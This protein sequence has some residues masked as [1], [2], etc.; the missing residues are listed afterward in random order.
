MHEKARELVALLSEECGNLEDVQAL[1][2]S[3]FKGTIERM[4]EAEMDE[5]LGYEKHSVLGNNSGNNRNGYGKKVLK[6]ELGETEIEVPRDRNGEFSPRVIEKRQTR[7]DDLENRILAMY[8]KG[9]SNRD[10]EDH[11]RDIYGV[12]ASASLISRITDKILPAV[13][14]WQSRPLDAVYP[15]VFLDGIVF[16]VRKDN[17]VINKCVYSVLG[18]NMDGHKEILGI[19]ISENESASFW[20]TVCNELK[21][22]GVQDILIACRD[23][24]SG[25]STAI[26]TVF[27]KTEQQLC[28]IHQ[29][30]TSTKYVPYKDIKAVMADLKKVYGAPTMDDAEFRLEEFREKWGKKYPQILKSWD[31]NW[32]ELSTYFKYPQEVR[33]LIYTTNAVEGFHRMLRKYTKTKTIYPTDDAVRKSVYLSIMEIS[34]KWSMPIRDWGIIIGQLLVFFEGRLQPQQ[35]S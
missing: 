5:H 27:P 8:A 10:I 18:I 35:A 34:K 1:L 28:V 4:L 11:L 6:T 19:W 3:L 32:I 21:N 13:Q 30:R 26:E 16:K 29:I 31:A 20:T 24:L 12:E 2:K 17:R 7:S 14:E 9:M 22:R 23:N 15:I 25:F 33:T